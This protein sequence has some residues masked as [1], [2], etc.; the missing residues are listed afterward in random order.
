[1]KT[2]PQAAVLSQLDFWERLTR[3]RK[4][5]DGAHARADI[6]AHLGAARNRKRALDEAVEAHREI[7]ALY[8]STTH[9]NMAQEIGGSEIEY[10]QSLV[11]RAY[12]NL[13]GE[14]AS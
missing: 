12:L 4:Q 10:A 7:L 11:G 3:Y 9:Q 13:I 14:A 5:R 6:G 8:N 2:L 1:M